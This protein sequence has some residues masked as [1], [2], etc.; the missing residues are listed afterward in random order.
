M[1]EIPASEFDVRE[2]DAKDFVQRYRRRLPLPQ[3]QQSL[4]AH[5]A[6]MRQELV[7]LI[8]EK[9]AD[10]VS[11]STRMQGV[12]RALK[13]LKA[14]LEESA[15]LTR[16]M[17][18]KL[19]GLLSQAE[20]TRQTLVSLHERKE[21]LLTYVE[22]ARLLANAKAVDSHKWGNPQDSDGFLREHVAQENVAHDLRRIRLGLGGSLKGGKVTGTDF[23][24]AS[25]ECQ[26]LLQEAAEFEEGFAAKLKEKLRGLV[27]AA[28][29]S[30]DVKDEADFVPSPSRNEVL[31][32][33]HLGRALAT[34]GR[35]A[36]VES[37]FATVFAAPAISTAA[38]I[39]TR[40]QKR[41]RG[42]PWQF[43][44]LDL[45]FA[46]GQE[47]SIWSHSSAA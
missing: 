4:R 18:K 17:E 47:P 42:K 12:E 30:F 35:S 45:L 2:F 19:G 44:A 24:T 13:P 29:R 11:L 15:E 41:R 3:L 9:Y 14:P 46:L 34:I 7:E 6:G 25:P 33:A 32:I 21:A 43:P 10:F 39:C 26:A 16:E 8:N 20:A 28:R 23:I 36:L 40:Q 1:D 31:A 22:H 37:V 38:A 27:A 5:H